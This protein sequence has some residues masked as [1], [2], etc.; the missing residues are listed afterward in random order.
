MSQQQTQQQQSPIPRNSSATVWKPDTDSNTIKFRLD[1]DPVKRDLQIKLLGLMEKLV[2]DPKT[3]DIRREY[4]QVGKPRVN[5]VGLQ[6]VMLHVDGVINAMTVQGNFTDEQYIDFIAD[7]H[8][9]FAADLWINAPEY[10]IPDEYYNGVVA[11]VTN[12]VRAFMTRPIANKEREAL[13]ES[14]KVSETVV[15]GRG[16][17]GGGSWWTRL[18]PGL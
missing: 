18:I 16:G 8:E 14:Q 11:A 9:E 1:A 10:G 12:F 4:V 2:E 3:G 13:G 6:A 15:T 17:S 7:F 5:E